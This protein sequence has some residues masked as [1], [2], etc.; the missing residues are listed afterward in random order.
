MKSWK[1]F[2]GL[3]FTE[4]PRKRGGDSG[5]ELLLVNWLEEAACQTRCHLIDGEKLEPLITT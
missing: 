2:Y 3:K 1:G 4:R 5:L